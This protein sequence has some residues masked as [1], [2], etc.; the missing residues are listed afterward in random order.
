MSLVAIDTID[1]EWT[2]RL[3]EALDEAK[4][5]VRK[6]GNRGIV[7][8]TANTDGTSSWH[9][10]IPRGAGAGPIVGAMELAKAD[11]I[12]GNRTTSKV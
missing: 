10:M 3:L 5:V 11:I 1:N 2:A 7:I 12:R 4:E 6:G 9:M 8:V